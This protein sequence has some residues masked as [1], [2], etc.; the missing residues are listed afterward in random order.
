MA[1]LWEGTRQTVVFV[2]HDLHEAAVLA[3][4][5]VVLKRGRIA[6]E[7]SLEGAPPRGFFVHA[8]CEDELV[9]ILTSEIV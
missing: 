6:A 3:H 1:E 9:R 7:L 8:D 5:A 2:T 4:R